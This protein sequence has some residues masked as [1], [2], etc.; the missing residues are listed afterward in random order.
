[1]FSDYLEIETKITEITLKCTLCGAGFRNRS[2]SES[3]T[4]QKQ[5][6]LIQSAKD[7]GWKEIEIPG[8]IDLACKSCQA[9]LIEDGTGYKEV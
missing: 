4:K 5:E 9:D 7:T 8:Q 3:E 1:M 2:F 6:K